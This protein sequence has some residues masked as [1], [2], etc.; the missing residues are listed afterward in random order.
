MD[1]ERLMGRQLKVMY[2]Q[3]SNGTHAKQAQSDHR[4]KAR[5]KMSSKAVEPRPLDA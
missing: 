4:S 2:A 5:R 1:N 3:P